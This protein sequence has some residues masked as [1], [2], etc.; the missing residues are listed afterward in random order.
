MMA[1]TIAN[2]TGN[3]IPFASGATTT[4]FESVDVQNSTEFT[5]NAIYAA[6][7]DF[8]TTVGT[9]ADSFVFRISEDAYAGDAQFTV[10]IDG[11]QQGDVMTAFA[12]HSNGESQTV[13]VK[14]DFGGGSGHAAVVTFLN[15]AYGG[16]PET[17]RNLYVDAASFNG[18]SLTPSSG[19]FFNQGSMSFIQPPTTLDT[20]YVALTED[21]YQGDAQAEISIDGRVL[22]QVT[23]TAPNSGDAQQ[24]S[25]TGNFGTGAHTVGVNFLNDAYAGTADTDRNLFVKGVGFNGVFHPDATANIVSNGLVAFTI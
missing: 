24:F 22:G 11:V 8:D 5:S 4:F 6:G 9:R 2:T 10:S 7:I 19:A 15:D 23:V 16:S 3:P 1:V 14:G 25:F 12:L 17:D 21:A 13:E 20:L 18:A